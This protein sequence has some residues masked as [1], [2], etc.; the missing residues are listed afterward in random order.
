MLDVNKG[1]KFVV[2]SP[3]IKSYLVTNQMKA[4]KQYFHVVL[5]TYL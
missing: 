4:L 2:L 5:I 1:L 3:Q